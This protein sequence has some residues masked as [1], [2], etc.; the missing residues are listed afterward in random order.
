MSYHSYKGSKKIG[1]AQKKG[2]GWF[3]D[4]AD[5]FKTGIEG[6]GKI[7]G[8]VINLASKFAGYDDMG[9]M[10]GIALGGLPL[11][12]MAL[13]GLPLGGM[14]LG[15][16][17]LGGAHMTAKG[18]RYVIVKGHRKYLDTKSGL[19]YE[20]N[21]DVNKLSLPSHRVKMAKSHTSETATKRRV[22]ANA[23]LG[24]YQEFARRCRAQHPGLSKAKLSE[25]WKKHKAQ[26]GGGIGSLLLSGLTSLF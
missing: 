26:N 21:K 7:A 24:A 3:D 13:G 15:G 23:G 9:D 5:G 12:G 20:I 17:A 10:G 22:G 8:P 18:R 25:M 19:K 2:A 1:L 6:V 14:A 16:M 11:G 4:F